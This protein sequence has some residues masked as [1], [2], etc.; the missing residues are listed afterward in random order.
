MG[1]LEKSA[2]EHD[3]ICSSKPQRGYLRARPEGRASGVTE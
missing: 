3:S 1:F 2:A